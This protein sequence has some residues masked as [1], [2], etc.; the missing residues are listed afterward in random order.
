[1]KEQ[2]CSLSFIK[3]G[4]SAG[5]GLAVLTV[6]SSGSVQK[7]QAFHFLSALMQTDKQ[8]K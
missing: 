2:S 1:M 7:G 3:S 8:V 6:G 4:S 5:S